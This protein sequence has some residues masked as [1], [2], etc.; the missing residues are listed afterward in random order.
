MITTML[1][2]GRWRETL[3]GR[4]LLLL[5]CHAVPIGSAR[6]QTDVRHMT[7]AGGVE[8]EAKVLDLVDEARSTRG[9]SLANDPGA[10]VVPM[11]RAVCT[12]GETAV[13][14]IVRPGTSEIITAYPVVP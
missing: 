8:F 9:A 13:K 5:A 7:S 14:I 11:G 10:F 3:L 2:R 12:Q 1:L 4:V 6:A